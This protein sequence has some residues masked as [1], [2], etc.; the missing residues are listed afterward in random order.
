[1]KRDFVVGYRL[2]PYDAKVVSDFIAA[3]PE[4]ANFEISV[5]KPQQ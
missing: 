2:K 4:L 1:M 5:A 3:A